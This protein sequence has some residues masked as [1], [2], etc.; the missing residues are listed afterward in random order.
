METELFAA[1]VA[2]WQDADVIDDYQF[3]LSIVQELARVPKTALVMIRPGSSL[4]TRVLAFQRERTRQMY[5]ASFPE[6]GP[7]DLAYARVFIEE[8]TVSVIRAWIEAGFPQSP[9]HIAVVLDQLACRM[10]R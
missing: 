9:E 6:M 7:D 8:G 4:I 3:G 2:R 5:Q 1:F 10:Q